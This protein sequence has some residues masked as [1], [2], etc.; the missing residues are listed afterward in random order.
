MRRRMTTVWPR[1]VRYWTVAAG[2]AIAAAAC[3]GA[4]G[5]ARDA[6]V[7][8]PGSG[9]SGPNSGAGAGSIA[10]QQQPIGNGAG[11]ANSVAPGGVTNPVAP[12]PGGAG[13]NPA[14]AGAQPNAL[15]Q[16]PG[17]V[18]A[19]PAAPA[20]VP[21]A[22]G[23]NFASDVGV[24]KDQIN[25][26][27]INFSSATRSLGPVV[28]LPSQRSV[29]ALVRYINETGGVAGRKL[30]LI[31]CDDGG[32][33]TRARSCYE[34]LKGQ[35]F[36]FVPGES[37]VYDVIHDQLGQDKVPWLSRGYFKS[38][39]QDPYMFPC[40]A[41]GLREATSLAKWIAVHV[42]PQSVGI[43][44]LNVSEDIAA[45]DAGTRVL[46]QYGI[47]VVQSIGQEWDSPDES[48][49]VLAM[50]V[51]NPDMVISY[52]FGTPVA[53]FLHD[54]QG[55]NWMPKF[56]YAAKHLTGDPA[57]GQL[58]GDS[59]KG[60]M[61][62]ITSYVTPAAQGQT[63]PDENL[64][65]LKL[66]EMLTAKYTGYDLAG[67]HFKY[68]M[69]HHETQSALGCVKVL[70]DATRALGANLTRPRFIDY[71]ETHSFD[72]GMGQVLAWPHGDH[73]REPY[74]FNREYLYEWEGTADGGY[75]FK[76]VLPDPTN[77]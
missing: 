49:H 51:A 74:C 45:R 37:W 61:L 65:G 16:H 54:A 6:S 31:A 59:M 41:N 10:Q 7:A 76:R 38:E 14:A 75:D 12:A 28:S 69:G 39:W 66:W 19:K 50:R 15:P 25:I 20:P 67:L 64:P 73:G 2:V 56:G 33:V 63:P 21:G 44:Y 22:S 62:T 32:D 71:L 43:L 23:A 55:Q 34:K 72:T 58:F 68:T 46:E 4:G 1:H 29:D 42:H 11:A 26:G 17:G 8:Q 77:V 13:A 48:Q 30:N 57:Y 24:S 9:V 53:K 36:A 60:H 5:G 70:A 27:L 40:H 35:V 3:G 18:A 52:S 47:K